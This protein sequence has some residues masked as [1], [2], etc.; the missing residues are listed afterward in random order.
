[1]AGEQQ[2]QGGDGDTEDGHRSSGGHAG[3]ERATV[4]AVLGAPPVA[5]PGGQRGPP[6]GPA[7]DGRGG[8]AEGREQQQSGQ[9]RPAQLVRPGQSA[10]D[11]SG[12]A[13][14]P[15]SSIAWSIKPFTDRALRAISSAA[16]ATRPEDPQPWGFGDPVLGRG[17]WQQDDVEIRQAER[18][19]QA[20]P[21][22]LL[23]VVYLGELFDQALLHRED[24]V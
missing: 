16:P 19:V 18:S 2:G 22:C 8:Q 9:Q 12:A 11:P 5:Q 13:T 23:G 24:R 21:R 15:A 1:M 4:T 20:V 3:G 14:I 7:V 6:G 10:A 17:R